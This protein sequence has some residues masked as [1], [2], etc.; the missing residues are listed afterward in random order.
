LGDMDQMLAEF[1][2]GVALD[3]KENNLVEAAEK[4]AKLITDPETPQK[5]RALAE[6]YFDLSY[7]NH[8]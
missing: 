4:F 5:C 8:V 1:G 7:L 3:G 6:K 2:A